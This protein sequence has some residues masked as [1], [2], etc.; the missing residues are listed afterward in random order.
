MPLPAS[1]A[2]MK[3]SPSVETVYADV[4]DSLFPSTPL[5]STFLERFFERPINQRLL[6]ILLESVQEATLPS[7]Y[8]F[9]RTDPNVRSL[10]AECTMI[11]FFVCQ[12]FKEGSLTS[13]EMAYTIIFLD[14]IKETLP[15]MDAGPLS[16]LC[17]SRSRDS[18]SGFAER[19]P[20]RP[21]LLLLRA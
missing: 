21:K 5:P 7:V 13:R 20:S 16:A 19:Q 12:V 2:S 3:H 15:H 1:P 10:S 17:I 18:R 9:L 14:R 4:I 11:S 8:L 6:N